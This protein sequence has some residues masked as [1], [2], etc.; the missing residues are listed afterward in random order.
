MPW[1]ETD[2]V[3]ERMRFV[4]RLREEGKGSLARLCREFGISRKTGEKIKA[5]YLTEGIQGLEDKSRAPHSIPH[6]TPPEVQTLIVDTKKRHPSW[7][8]KKLRAWLEAKNPGLV[9]PSAVTFGYWL[10]KAG[11][12]KPRMRRRKAQAVPPSELT[13]A[14]RPNQVW[15]TDFKGEFLLGNGRY[16]Y[17]LTITDLFSRYL[18]A[19]VALETTKAAVARAVFEEVFQDYGLPEV[20][21]SDNGCPFA[22]VGLAVLRRSRRTGSGWAF[23]L[24]GSSRGT[25]SRTASTSAFT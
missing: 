25:R 20:I 21:R 2:A 14:T 7:G 13:K 4:A 9:L 18:I 6:R 8:P 10:R 1:K 5:R 3:E 11:L 22:S 15:A 19:V 16:C 12:I 17:P 23:A 24:S